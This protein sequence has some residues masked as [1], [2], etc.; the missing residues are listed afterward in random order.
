MAALPPVPS[1]L[2]AP[3]AGRVDLLVIAGEHSGDQHAARMVREALQAAPGL[4]VCAVGGP[5]LKG[6]GAQLLFDLTDASVVGLIEVL[7]H[8]SYFKSL[9]ERLLSWI[10]E[11]KPRAV[12]FVDYPGFNLR[13]A[14]ALNDRALAQKA[15]GPVRLLY[16]I[17]PQIWAWKQKRRFTMARDLNALAVI[18]PF[19]VNCYAD[20]DLDVAY[21]G[22]PFAEADF[23]NPVRYSE[24]GDILLFPGSRPQAVGRIFPRMLGG[25]ESLLRDD[26]A[27][28]ATVLYPGERIRQLMQSILAEADPAVKATVTLRPREEGSSG[29]AVLTS[30]GTISLCCALAGIPGGIVYRA[31]PLTYRFGRLVAKVEYLGMANLLLNRTVYPEYIQKAARAPVLGALLRDFLSDTTAPGRFGAVAK[32]LQHLLGEARTLNASQWLLRQL[33]TA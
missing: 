32:E 11:Y 16:Y 28:R 17:S 21:V 12:C 8:Y 6:A 1:A 26:S 18:F 25:F 13:L 4:K 9:F 33:E 23:V 5:E 15:G 30:S 2:E 3:H 14:K 31:H 22:H 27:P 7:K 24:S 10:A 20:T 29:S 19:E